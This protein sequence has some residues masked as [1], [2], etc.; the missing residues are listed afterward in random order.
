MEEIATTF[1]NH[2]IVTCPTPFERIQL[3]KLLAEIDFGQ[4]F[5]CQGNE[6]I[7]H[8]NRCTCICTLCANAISC[9]CSL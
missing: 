7:T 3:C 5:S 8:D 2:M 4:N 9:T 6:G 1:A